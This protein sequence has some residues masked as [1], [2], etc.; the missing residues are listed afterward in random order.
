MRI[1]TLESSASSLQRRSA[2]VEAAV[3]TGPV[4]ELRYPIIVYSGGILLRVCSSCSWVISCDSLP[5]SLG[6]SASA[7]PVSCAHPASPH[8]G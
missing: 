4:E 1:I 3:Q 7:P 8:G 5:P 2:T 6:S